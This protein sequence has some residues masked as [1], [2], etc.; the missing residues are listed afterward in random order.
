MAYWVTAYLMYALLHLAECFIAR[1]CGGASR[2]VRNESLL[3]E[4]SESW[5]VEVF[6]IIYPSAVQPTARGPHAARLVISC[7]PPSAD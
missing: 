2:L 1:Q 6:T 3:R 4:S 7:G 5:Y